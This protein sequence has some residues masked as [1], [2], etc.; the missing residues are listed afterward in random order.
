[1]DCLEKPKLSLSTEKIE[2]S[3]DSFVAKKFPDNFI[4]P[5]NFTNRGMVNTGHTCIS[6]STSTPYFGV[7]SESLGLK[8]QT[9]STVDGS[10]SLIYRHLN[11]SLNNQSIWFQLQKNSEWSDLIFT[12]YF[13]I[14]GEEYI[15]N[16][17]VELLKES[18]EDSLDGLSKQFLL[19]HSE[20]EYLAISPMFHHGILAKLN[21]MKYTP[22]KVCDFKTKTLGGTKPGNISYTVSL[23]RGALSQFCMPFPKETSRNDKRLYILA[24]KG[25]LDLSE[26]IESLENY[27]LLLTS[28]GINK[29]LRRK[30][31][32]LAYYLCK[33]CLFQLDSL[34]DSDIKVTQESIITLT[35]PSSRNDLNRADEMFLL[36]N[37]I[38]SSIRNH[39]GLEHQRLLTTQLVDAIQ[40]EVA[41]HV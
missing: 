23:E 26:S 21:R 38:F 9:F 16:I 41:K 30:E 32:L 1:M 11:L 39:K 3:F 6:E 36:N 15:D 19:P 37:L 31:Q 34:S 27:Q 17:R 29:V 4:P 35:N 40:A 18:S 14:L 13:S 12:V 28:N 20:Y 8:K 24:T 2:L 5:S 10:Q 7:T 25:V 33:H 22:G